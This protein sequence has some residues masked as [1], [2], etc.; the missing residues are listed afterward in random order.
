[1]QLHTRG[2]QPCMFLLSLSIATIRRWQFLHSCCGVL[3]ITHHG[4]Y[5]HCRRRP[6][7]S[8]TSTVLRLQSNLHRQSLVFEMS[9][10]PSDLS[11]QP[12]QS[13]GSSQ[14]EITSWVATDHK[15]VCHHFS[16]I[17]L[18]AQ[19]RLSSHLSYRVDF[20]SFCSACQSSRQLA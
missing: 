15:T 13:L 2:E 3:A 10:S 7:N 8:L 5:H 12:E 19:V 14:V 6:Q 9:D 4:P 16:D 18:P 1:M 17:P 20:I 11:L